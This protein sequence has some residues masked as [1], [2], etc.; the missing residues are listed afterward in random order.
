MQSAFFELLKAGVSICICFPA[1][2]LSQQLLTGLSYHTDPPCCHWNSGSTL[3]GVEVWKWKLWSSQ[4]RGRL[5]SIFICCVFWCLFWHALGLL[6]DIF[7]HY[8]RRSSPFTPMFFSDLLPL[9][10][11]ST[12]CVR[13]DIGLLHLPPH[14]WERCLSKVGCHL[15]WR[16]GHAGLGIWTHWDV[17]IPA[18]RNRCS[19]PCWDSFSAPVWHPFTKRQVCSGLQLCL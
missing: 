11:F 9:P 12:R 17:S 3:V 19:K 1:R 10:H 16:D 8:F 4:S 18:G 13:R 15:R 5:K 6:K 2:F 14:L 7:S